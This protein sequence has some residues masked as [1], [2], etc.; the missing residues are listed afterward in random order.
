MAEEFS[1]FFAGV[2]VFT[3]GFREQKTY[4]RGLL[5]LWERNKVRGKG[6]EGDTNYLG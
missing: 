6:L 1:L 3:S 2:S 5:S 4:E